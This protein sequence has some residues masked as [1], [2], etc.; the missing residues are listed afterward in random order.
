MD[1]PPYGYIRCVI[2]GEAVASFHRT[3]RT[4]KRAGCKKADYRARRAGVRVGR[5]QRMANP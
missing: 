3:T 5:P 4:C 2:C 1:A